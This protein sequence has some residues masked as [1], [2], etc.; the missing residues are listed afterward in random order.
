MTALGGA[1]ALVSAL[2][3]QAQTVNESLRQAPAAANFWAGY[4]S[5]GGVVEFYARPQAGPGQRGPTEF[6]ARRGGPEGQMISTTTCPQIFG[7]LEALNELSPPRLRVPNVA[8]RN[9]AA[10]DFHPWTPT[11]PERRNVTVWGY[12]VQPD[13]SMA[14]MSVTAGTGY[15][16]DWTRYAD[17]Q[18][19]SCW[20]RRR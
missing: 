14:T 6:L 1:L 11:P 16:Y 18:L 19:Q 7:V 10:P 13:G 4:S 2:P 12:A 15:L 5:R 8:Q 17:D 9:A 20:S 3:A